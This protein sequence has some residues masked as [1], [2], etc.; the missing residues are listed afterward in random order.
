MKYLLIFVAA[1]C[2]ITLQAQLKISEMPTLPGN[3]NGSYIPIVQGSNN[4]KVNASQIGVNDVYVRNDSVI[5]LKQGQEVYVGNI[6]MD[7]TLFAVETIE[8][9]MAIPLG[10]KQAII[11]KDSLRGGLFRKATSGV[12]VDSGIVFPAAGGGYA[13]RDVSQAIGVKPEWFGA[14]GDNVHDDWLAI[15]TAIRFC[16]RKNGGTVRLTAGKKYKATQT[17]F[18]YKGVNIEGEHGTYGVS[19]Q[20]KYQTDSTTY[21]QGPAIIV[22]YA[23]GD[24]IKSDKTFAVDSIGMQLS[25]KNFV[26]DCRFQTAGSGIHFDQPN[27]DNGVKNNGYLYPHIFLERVTVL[28]AYEHGIWIDKWNNGPKVYN[29]MVHASGRGGYGNGFYL[30]SQD[31]HLFEC[32]SWDNV[33]AG[34]WDASNSLRLDHCDAWAN[35]PVDSTI[36]EGDVK[37]YSGYGLVTEGYNAELIRLQCDGNKGGGVAIIGGSRFTTSAR[38]IKMLDCWVYGNSQ[39][40]D[41]QYP[42]VFIGHTPGEKAIGVAINNCHFSYTDKKSKDS[43]LHNAGGTGYGVIHGLIVDTIPSYLL[44][45]NTIFGTGGLGDTTDRAMNAYGLWYADI[46]NCKEGIFNLNNLPIPLSDGQTQAT[47]TVGKIFMTNNTTPTNFSGFNGGRINQTVELVT[48]DDSTTFV[49]GNKLRGFPKNYTARK[50]ERM[51]CR[52]SLYTDTDTGWLCQLNGYN[53]DSAVLYKKKNKILSKVAADTID[54]RVAK[55]LKTYNSERAH[56]A[57]TTITSNFVVD[58]MIKYVHADASSGNIIIY[59]PTPTQNVINDTTYAT[60]LIITRLD[61]SANTVTIKRTG[62]KMIN[63]YDTLVTLARGE[64]AILVGESSTNWMVKKIGQTYNVHAFEEQTETT[65]SGTITWTGTTAPSGTETVTYAYTRNGS[66]VNLFMYYKATV[67]G[68]ALTQVTF[69]FPT[70]VPTP[71]IPNNVSG[72]NSILGYGAGLITTSFVTPGVANG[73]SFLQINSSNTGYLVGVV[74]ASSSNAAYG[75]ISIAYMTE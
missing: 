4:F 75:W 59:L 54:F 53:F 45:V 6:A 67:A 50:G 10:S 46:V 69:T 1:F 47:V 23:N 74:L 13:V 12:T 63:L 64:A 32:A 21:I 19:D 18:L 24:A 66:M 39:I 57:D 20:L 34:Y 17:I 58:N 55:F 29:C 42:D 40:D 56:G 14:K 3:P 49:F 73:K 71:K 11:V 8:Q 41:S 72:A 15:Q 52:Y 9:M 36:Y 26:L 61:T 2:S 70:G 38:N 25:L 16:F 60:D 37:D 22:S 65:Y 27:P 48:G 62:S 68:T 5:K 44:I 35:E 7:S 43:T 30:C 33:G 51:T 28:Y 31:T